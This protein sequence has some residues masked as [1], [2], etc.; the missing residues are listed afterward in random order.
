MRLSVVLVVQ[1]VVT[2]S[3]TD[4]GVSKN[5]LVNLL[6][7][8]CN[9]WLKLATSGNG[10]EVFAA[11]AGKLVKRKRGGDDLVETRGERRR[12]NGRESKGRVNSRRRRRRIF[13]N[14]GL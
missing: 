4:A 10:E 13:L 2:G 14:H 8:I 1:L 5:A 11:L 6:A 7:A 3:Q 12:E 9:S